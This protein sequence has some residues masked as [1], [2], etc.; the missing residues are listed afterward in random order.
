MPLSPCRLALA[1]VL[2]ATAV[3][4]P[5]DPALEARFAVLRG[6]L[7]LPAPVLDAQFDARMAEPACAPQLFA[8]A[9]PGQAVAVTLL[10]PCR[11]GAAFALSFGAVR[12]Q[13]RV[14]QNGAFLATLPCDPQ[15]RPLRVQWPQHPALQVAVPAQPECQPLG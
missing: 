10:A 15:A 6:V 5:A 4:A 11:P 8:D 2:C 3:P 9:L 14:S 13:G 12:L 1:C 7:G